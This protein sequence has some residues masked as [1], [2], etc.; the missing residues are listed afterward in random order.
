MTEAPALE[1]PRVDYGLSASGLGIDQ[2]LSVSRDSKVGLIIKEW[3]GH[4]SS[5]SSSGSTAAGTPTVLSRLAFEDSAEDTGV[6]RVQYGK[7]PS[8]DD[9]VL[10]VDRLP[11][12]PKSR[13]GVSLSLRVSGKGK[14]AFRNDTIEDL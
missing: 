14:P 11:R 2:F 9:D 3:V 10:I 7:T 6:L 13:I 5:W 12:R 1:I 8:L 4:V